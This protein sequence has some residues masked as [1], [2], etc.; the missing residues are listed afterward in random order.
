MCQYLSSFQISVDE[1]SK[2]LTVADRNG[3]FMSSY[4]VTQGETIELPLT[5]IKLKSLWEEDRGSGTAHN[6]TQTI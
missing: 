6:S 3:Y 4:Q 1:H 5:Q 2:Q